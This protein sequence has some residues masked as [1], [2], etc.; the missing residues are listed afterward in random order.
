MRKKRFFGDFEN[1]SATQGK[2]TKQNKKRKESPKER[3]QFTN[4]YSGKR[5]VG[6]WKDKSCTMIYTRKSRTCKK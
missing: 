6:Q 1:T 5:R 4:A 3:N 2:K